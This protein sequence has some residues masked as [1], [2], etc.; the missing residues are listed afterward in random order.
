[1]TCPKCTSINVRDIKFKDDVKQE[2]YYACL[3]CEQIMNRNMI[4]VRSPRL[5]KQ[6]SRN[7]DML[8]IIHRNRE[9]WI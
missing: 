2:D 9:A 8:C 1:M 6:I 5:I 7:R 4:P 3:D